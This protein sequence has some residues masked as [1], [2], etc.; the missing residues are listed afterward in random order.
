MTAC[1][2]QAASVLSTAQIFVKGVEVVTV[3]IALQVCVASQ[4]LVAVQTTVLLPPHANGAP[5]LL[6][7][8]VLLQPPE[9]LAVNNH[10][11]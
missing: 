9:A 2:W 6:L 11:A 4:L 10:A 1:V 3:K 8:N 7:V 5:V